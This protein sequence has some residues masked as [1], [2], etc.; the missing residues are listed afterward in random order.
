M[1]KTIDQL[2]KTCLIHCASHVDRNSIAEDE[3]FS[4]EII[5]G[6]IELYYKNSSDE[7]KN[8]I[9]QQDLINTLKKLFKKEKP[10]LAIAESDEL[11]TWLDSSRRINIETRF[12]CYKRLL[13]NEGKEEI[14][15]SMDADTYKIL[16][17]CHDPR[18]L[19][20]EWDR[21]GLVY[22][23]VQ[24][25]K[26]AN[27]IGLINRAFDAGYK[28]VIVL[29]GMTEDLR[30]QTQ[31]RIDS[32]VIGHSFQQPMGIGTDKEFADLERIRPATSI[33]KDLKKSDDIGN[34]L[35]IRDRSIW[36]VKKNKSVLENLI[37]WLDKQRLN[38]NGDEHDK[39]HN[40]PFL[41]IDDE[42]DNA[43]IQSLSKKDYEEWEIGIDL[44][45]LENLNEEQELKLEKAKERIVKAINRNIRV[46]LSLMSDKTFVGYAA[47]PYSIINQPDK[48]LKRDV[49][50][51]GKKFKIDV[52][53]L[54]PEHFIIP[55]NAGNKYMGIER[56]FTTELSRR[57]PILTNLS[58]KYPNENLDV[59]YFPTKRGES[60]SF[61]NIPKSLED[62]IIHFL[63]SIVIRKH[64]DHKDYNSMLIHTSHL[65]DN[66]DYVAE[67]VDKFI[68]KL[69]YY[70]PGNSGGY[71]KRFQD[72]FNEIKETSR[73]S[74]FDEYFN[75][76]EKYKFPNILSKHEILDVIHNITLVSYH[77]SN[78]KDLKH[79]NHDLSV[80]GNNYRSYIVVGGNR[81]ARGLTLEGLICSYFVRNSTRQDSLYQMGR[82][83]GYRIGFE[84]LVKIYMPKD[85]IYWF[86][87][88]YK[89]EMDLRKDFENNNSDDIPM[90]PRDYSIK[91]ACR[92]DLG[93]ITDKKIP[94]I[95]DP[96]KLRN[97]KKQLMTPS[98]NINTKRIINDIQIQKDNLNLVKVLMSKVEDDKDSLLFNCK[99]SKFD[100]I[101]KNNNINYSNVD[102]KLIVNFLE[103]Y[104]S[105]DFIKSNIDTL[106]GYIKKNNI[107]LNKWSLVIVN[108]GN[109]PTKL[110]IN[111][112]KISPVLRVSEEKTDGSLYF[113]QILEGRGL[114]NIFDIIEEKEENEAYLKSTKVITKLRNDKKKPIL[115]IYPAR[116][117]GML[118]DNVFPL[119]Y[120]FIPILDNAQK[121]T[122]IVR[123]K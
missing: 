65:T 105:E 118:Q 33:Q 84:D 36:V 24:S 55:I 29:T 13:I 108:R 57:L 92:T 101:K 69:I 112:I 46:A 15:Q 49:E 120:C 2:V 98:Q 19:E 1:N 54:F 63:V 119:I 72:I 25:G 16:D 5:K 59:N 37:L 32:G 21:R 11:Q 95:C 107:E 123:K 74:L 60:Y 83:F 113:N 12:N 42:A 45:D 85:Q 30:Q 86:E 100:V 111:N 64:R 10:T 81:L 35:S 58:L 88:I 109:Y 115:V 71:F 3:I 26:T 52:D 17:S 61:T 106:I 80:K 89:L 41:I 22:G 28:I 38:S 31:N 56:V 116:S 8:I 82:W 27:Y 122:Y 14:V 67:S 47:T 53:D 7:V 76:G 78:R 117:K 39:I 18:N 114:D 77:S 87:I 110:V 75:P 102:N 6:I 40:L 90:L 79:H 91:L 50:I 66:A 93:F 62:A 104:K 44:A 51:N 4:N 9:S 34:S 97:T 94:F 103:S 70:L 20:R 99:N 48:D 23:H 43:S 68:S 73:N 96:Q 121:V